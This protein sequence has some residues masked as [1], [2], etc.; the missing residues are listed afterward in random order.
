MGYPDQISSTVGQSEG[1]ALQQSIVL[2][3][4]K[5]SCRKWTVLVKKLSQL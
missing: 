4:D 1:S 2:T 3:P 5:V